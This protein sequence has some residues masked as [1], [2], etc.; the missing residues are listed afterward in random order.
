MFLCVEEVRSH[1]LPDDL[2]HEPGRR[3]A[4]PCDQVEDLLAARLALEGS[5]MASTRPLI[6][7]TRP[8]SFFLS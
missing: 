7:R 4:H 1:V 2:A 8:R 5:S 3:A 6:R